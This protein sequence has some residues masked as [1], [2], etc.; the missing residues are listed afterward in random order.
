VIY[1]LA[2]RRHSRTLKTFLS[3]WARD[4]ASRIEVLPYEDLL[5]RP[6]FGTGTYV[7][8]D[9]ERLSAEQTKRLSQL[10][11]ELADPASGCRVINHPARSMRRYELLR[12]LNERGLNRF[13]IHR[14]TDRREPD[15]FPVFLRR[16]N[17]HYGNLTPLL[18]HRSDLDTAVGSL[19][20]KG[21]DL[22]SLVLVEFCDTSDPQGVF[23]KYSA[24]FVA[25]RVIP[26]H[27]M[28]SRYWMVKSSLG[29]TRSELAE[30]RAYVEGNPHADRLKEIFRVARID[31]GRIDYGVLD[32]DVQTW[33]I[34][35]NPTMLPSRNRFKRRY[36]KKLFIE[37]IRRAFVELDTTPEPT[38]EIPVRAAAD[39]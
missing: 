12:T 34:N 27:L 13:D 35:T 30:E 1:Y 18:S 5:D 37:Q 6:S 15:R 25:G 7:F 31:Y 17:D 28:F 3:L 39:G 21:E 38:R 22:E 14:L 11:D 8:S 33:E 9:V 26:V 4:L 24:Y 16:E 32:G 2:T 29:R 36:V 19:R 10:R 20:E 23:R